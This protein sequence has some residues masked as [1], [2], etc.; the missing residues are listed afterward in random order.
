[1]RRG[2]VCRGYGG[3]FTNQSLKFCG[4]SGC[5]HTKRGIPSHE[6]KRKEAV[7]EYRGNCFQYLSG[8]GV[9]TLFYYFSLDIVATLC[10]YFFRGVYFSF[11]KLENAKDHSNRFDKKTN[12][13]FI[14]EKK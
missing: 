6:W 4:C 3:I 1:M 14:N 11:T 10:I 13:H 12:K 5:Y 8:S 7:E 2:K 9:L